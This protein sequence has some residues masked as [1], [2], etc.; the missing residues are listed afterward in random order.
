MSARAAPGFVGDPT[1]LES[2]IARG[3]LEALYT[4]DVAQDALCARLVRAARKAGVRLVYAEAAFDGPAWSEFQSR[5]PIPPWGHPDFLLLGAV[6][7]G[8]I[9]DDE[10][11]LIATTRLEDVPV[12]QVAAVLGEPTNTVVQRRPA[13]RTASPRRWPRGRSQRCRPPPAGQDPPPA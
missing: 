11:D 9:T 5:A 3:F 1:D 7:A 8:V 13:P 2:E 10:A 12:D 6:D 4:V